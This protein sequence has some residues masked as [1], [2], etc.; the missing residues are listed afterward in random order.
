VK[1]QAEVTALL[2]QIFDDF[3]IILNLSTGGEAPVGLE[4]PDRPDNCL[5]WT[6]CGVPVLN[7]PVFVGPAGLPFG[8]QIVA[9]KYH[10]YQLLDFAKFLWNEELIGSGPFPA[11]PTG[12]RAAG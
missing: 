11:L 5:I 8:A 1:F 6:F 12:L 4:A 2:D 9:R 7:L 10:D 3:N